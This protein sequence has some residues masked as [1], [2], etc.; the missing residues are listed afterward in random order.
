MIGKWFRLKRADLNLNLKNL[1]FNIPSWMCK[2]ISKLKLYFLKSSVQTSWKKFKLDC[3]IFL[4]VFGCCALQML[5][6]ICFLRFLLEKHEKEKKQEMRQKNVFFRFVPKSENYMDQWAPK[7][8][9][10]HITYSW[11]L[12]FSWSTVGSPF[13]HAQK[14]FEIKAGKWA[15][16]KI[17]RSAL[18]SD[19][20]F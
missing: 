6:E 1:S 5:V 11:R 19:K 20:L 16:K 13:H 15:T 10:L 14:L 17:F 18:K 2:W 9:M 4:P 7:R 3:Y 8:C 12:P